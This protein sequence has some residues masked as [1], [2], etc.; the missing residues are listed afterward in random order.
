[1][2]EKE[3]SQLPDDPA[4]LYEDEDVVAADSATPPQS[5]ADEI[6]ADP[7]AED[8]SGDS[9]ATAEAGLDSEDVVERFKP[10]ADTDPRRA[11]IVIAKKLPGRRLD[12]YLHGR[13]RKISRTIIQ[14]QIKRGEITVNG[15]PTK[16]SYE[17]EAGDVID[18]SFP[19]PE[20]YEV[21][22]ENIPLDIVYEDDYIIAVNKPASM[23]VHPARREQRGTIANALAY[24]SAKLAKT[25]DPFRPGIVHRLDKNTTG[26]MVVAK[27]DEVH[28]RLSLQF[29][30]RETEKVYVAVVH[31][32]PTFDEDV[33]DVPIG[34]HPTV[35]DRYVATGFAERMGGKFAKKLSKEAVTRYKVLERFSGF[36]LVELYPKTGRTHQ[37]RI[38]MSHIRHPIVGDPFYGGRNISL[39]HATGRPGDSDEIRWKRQMLHAHRLRVTHP[40]TNQPLEVTAPLAPDMQ[41]LLDTLREFARPS[42]PNF[43]PRRR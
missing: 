25:D 12:K 13:F 39:R 41:E 5:S 36:S 32:A 38:H 27:T 10:A 16:N 4:E 43:K 37:L 29:E 31:G 28:W 34:Q 17:M 18:M 40:I 21:T 26:I 42:A 14:R 11:K 20:P 22:P 9:V 35:H 1:M 24:Y 2:I 23:I 30:R 6:P 3:P 33:I 15:K 19:V 7:F 8:D